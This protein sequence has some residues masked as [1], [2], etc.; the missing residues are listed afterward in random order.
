[1]D[2]LRRFLLRIVATI[3]PGRVEDAYTAMLQFA[4]A[5]VGLVQQC[6]AALGTPGRTCRVVGEA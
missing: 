5:A 4:T 3:R 6:S 1:M 2:A